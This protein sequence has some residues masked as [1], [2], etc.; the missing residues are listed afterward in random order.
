[1]STIISITGDLGS[2]KSTVSSLLRRHL[3]YGYIYTG[4][5]QR[6][7]AEK[8]GMTTTE[9]NKYAETH[10]EID[11]EIDNTFRSLNNA[12]DLIVD[13]RLA[14]FFIP[15]SF[16]VF[17]KINL[18]VSAERIIRDS[19]RKNEQYS[20]V[21]EAVCH[22]TERKQ[23]ENKRYMQLYG[24]DCTDLSRFDLIVDTSFVSPEQVTGIILEA[25]R[26]WQTGKAYTKT[27]ISPQNLYP[28]KSV[29]KLWAWDM[30]DQPVQAVHADAFDF[31]VDGH[32][33]VSDAL[34][35][36]QELIPVIYINSKALH[37]PDITFR[38]HVLH[39]FNPEVI[40]EWEQ[41][42]SFKYL[43]CPIK[44]NGNHLRENH[45]R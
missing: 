3:P 2:G 36:A 30:I 37:S 7:I 16:K 44:H 1:M 19:R 35:N 38:E 12:S 26:H 10:P 23:S 40:R 15:A 20:S 31:I 4:A 18:A 33:R 21:E 29:K 34:K 25:Y 41:F 45:C 14:W 32:R 42:H 22:I 11:E 39:T 9:L 8:Y 28:I 13:S 43:T 24:A 17:L 6:K 27:L 5:I